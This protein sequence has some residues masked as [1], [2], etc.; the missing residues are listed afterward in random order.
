MASRSPQQNQQVG[1]FEQSLN[2]FQEALG[3]LNPQFL[4]IAQG[5]IEQGQGTAPNPLIEA[6]RTRGLGQLQA[7]LS[8]R[9]ITG[10]VAANE[11]SRANQGFNERAL[12]AQNQALQ[13]GLQLAQGGLQNLLAEPAIRTAQTAAVNA[14]QSSGG[15]GGGKK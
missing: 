15:G 7:G 12:A 10:S 2:P 1:Q 14:G 6:Q 11:L 5:L 3:Q 8:R 9:G 13:G 4:D